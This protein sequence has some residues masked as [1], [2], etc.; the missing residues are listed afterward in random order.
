MGTGLSAAL[1]ASLCC[2]AP[3]LALVGGATGAIS[4]FGWVEPFRPYLIAIT[5]VV[6]AMAWY[7]RLQANKAT[8]ACGCEE[9]AKRAF[10]KSNKFLLVI[11]CMALLLLAFPE[12]AGALYRQPEAMAASVQTNFMKTVKLEVKGMSCEGC[13]AHVNREVGK[14]AGVFSVSTFYE[15]GSAVVKY[16]STKVQPAQILQAARKTGYTVVLEE[17]KP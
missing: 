8:T 10:W 16:D 5:L 7:Q 3:L 9:D 4:A 11:S 14:L 13:E 15:K 6:L 1:L 17:K 2:I 12:Y